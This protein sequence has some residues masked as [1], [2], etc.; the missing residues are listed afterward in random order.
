MLKSTPGTARAAWSTEN[1][2]KDI[3]DFWT[4]NCTS[5][6]VK[7]EKRCGEC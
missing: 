3:L 6:V 5:I 7:G 2:A 4:P 1:T